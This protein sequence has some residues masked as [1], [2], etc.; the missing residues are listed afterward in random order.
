MERES[1]PGRPR[2]RPSYLNPPFC[3]GAH[4]D[5]AS[6]S[7]SRSRPHPWPK[8][9]P[10]REPPGEGFPGQTRRQPEHRQRVRRSSRTE[11]ASFLSSPFLRSPLIGYRQSIGCARYVP[12]MARGKTFE[13][14]KISDFGTIGNRFRCG[15]RSKTPRFGVAAKVNPKGRKAGFDS[16]FRAFYCHFLFGAAF[17]ELS[18]R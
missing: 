15:I 10:L 11:Y 18:S 9:P 14:A 13:R 12:S 6:G 7:P 8:R 1:Q 16:R 2:H 3:D 17:S 4:G 5:D